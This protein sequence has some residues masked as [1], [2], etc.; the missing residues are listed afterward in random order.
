METIKEPEIITID[1]ME[2]NKAYSICTNNAFIGPTK[3]CIYLY[4]D[5]NRIRVLLLDSGREHLY[6]VL[7]GCIWYCKKIPTCPS[8]KVGHVRYLMLRFYIKDNVEIA[9]PGNIK[10]HRCDS[11]SKLHMDEND[12]KNVT[13]AIENIVVAA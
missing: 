2:E 8:C 1:Q 5:G 3:D 7:N 9:L 11:C 12:E 10:V 6:T 13:I 4:K